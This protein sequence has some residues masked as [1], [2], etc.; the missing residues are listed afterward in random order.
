MKRRSIISSSIAILLIGSIIW[1]TL[2]F[3]KIK[4][5]DTK[6]KMVQQGMSVSEVTTIMDQKGTWTNHFAKA[7]WDDKPLGDSDDARISKTLKYTVSTFFL[8]VSFEFTFDEHGKIVGKHRY[9]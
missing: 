7:W 6:Y 8:P 3:Y 5:L 2:P 1:L 4:R 9:D